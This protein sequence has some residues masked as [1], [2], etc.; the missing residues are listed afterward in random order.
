MEDKPTYTFFLDVQK[1]YDTVWLVVEIVGYGE[2]VACSK[3][4]V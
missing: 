1:V 4:N 3:G 2:D